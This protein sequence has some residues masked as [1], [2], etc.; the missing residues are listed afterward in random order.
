MKRCPKCR[1]DYWDDSLSYCLDDGSALLEGPGSGAQA[2]E[3]FPSEAPTRKV[4]DSSSS[5]YLAQHVPGRARSASYKLL[6]SIAAILVAAVAAAVYL[7]YPQASSHVPPGSFRAVDSPAYDYYLRGKIDASS[8]NAER[9]ENAIKILETVVAADPGFAPAYAELARAYG[10]KADRFAPESEKKKLYDDAKVAVEKSLTL[11][12]DLATGHLVRGMIIWN[13]NNRFPH[14]QTILSL[15][16]ALALDPNMSEAHHQLGVVYYHIGLLD[17]SM[18]ELQKAVELDPSNAL[19]RFR[20]GLVS[21]YQTDY[22]QALKVLKTVPRDANPPVIE[23]ALAGVLFQ[24][25]R[26]TEATAAVD[27]FL[28]NNPDEGG[29]V[30]SVKAMLLAKA[31]RQRE[32]EDVIAHAIEI[33]G[34]FQHFH[35][36]TYNVAS[37]YAL[38]GNNDKALEWL[39][40]TADDGF[41]CYPY[42]EKDAS[43]DNLRN[44]ERFIKMM[45]DLKQQWE[46]YR[47]SL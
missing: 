19:A 14:E 23:R 38:I 37:A 9:N 5:N 12:P 13:H 10:I 11:D 34:S 3:V 36:T 6:L 33:G 43:L 28:A 44:D 1:R 41:P 27:D 7:Y 30:T 22:E 39:Q 8:Q 16:R 46:R 18:A 26:F 15:K 20:I 42:F 29:N 32:A 17:K 45:A 40:Y 24:L 31:G 2:T 25:G 4:A 21:A 35:H 47:A